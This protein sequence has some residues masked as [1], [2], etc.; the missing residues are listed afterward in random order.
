MAEL[1]P[2]EKFQI[3]DLVAYSAG[4]RMVARVVSEQEFRQKSKIPLEDYLNGKRVSLSRE[5]VLLLRNVHGYVAM[6][7][8]TVYE[9]DAGKEFA[10][11]AERLHS[12]VEA[13]DR[14]AGQEKRR[15]EE[16]RNSLVGD[17]QV[18]LG[19]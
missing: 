10:D 18:V 8:N 14:I 11:I 7:K 17:L 1:N 3:G 5:G 15:L 12:D 19:L 13:V 2:S 9:I 6:P 16:A 4:A